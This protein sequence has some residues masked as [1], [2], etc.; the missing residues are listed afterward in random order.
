[1]P[2]WLAAA[3]D[4]L[5]SACGRLL[6]HTLPQESPGREASVPTVAFLSGGAASVEWGYDARSFWSDD[7]GTSR[8]TGTHDAAECACEGV[9]SIAT[10][11][12]AQEATVRH[13]S[14][15]R[16]TF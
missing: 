10:E 3:S 6:A 15:S 16:R 14:T 1:M 4:A 12:P 5:E 7:A 13:P 2:H 8:C 11:H 9:G